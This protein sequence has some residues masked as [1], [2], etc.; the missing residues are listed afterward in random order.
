MNRNLDFIVFGVPR[1][2]TSA[3]A[4]YLGAVPQIHCGMELF[5]NVLDHSTLSVPDS[6][7]K[8]PEDGKPKFKHLYSKKDVSEN[9]EVIIA[10]G[11]KAPAYFY[12]L[13]GILSET[14]VKKVLICVRDLRECTRSYSSRAESESD[15]W[16]AGR[17]G[18]FAVSDMMLLIDQVAS[19]ETDVEI[20]IIPY[21]A[22][23]RDWRK[24]MTKAAEFIVPGI[25]I[26]YDKDRL[27]WTEKARDKAKGKTRAELT[28]L[29]LEALALIDC[30]R[31][32][33]LFLKDEPFLLSTIVEE[34]R[35]LR[36]DLPRQP[37]ELLADLAA[38]HKSPEAAEFMKPYQKW[39]R[40]AVTD[41]EKRR[42]Q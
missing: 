30:D 26:E 21:P 37:L 29:D 4:R 9:R 15:P 25:E 41:Y 7:L 13:N 3:V 24:T 23:S 6:F 12:R 8:L 36:D 10:Y 34:L 16:N 38:R 40:F 11:N 17:V 18:I 31:I 27:E 22:L 2:G 20:M 5:P 28:D 39:T 19:L 1:S 33:A 14:G 42:A 35:A 32:E